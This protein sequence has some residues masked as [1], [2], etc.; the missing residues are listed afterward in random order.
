MKPR[1]DLVAPEELPIE[2]LRDYDFEECIY[3]LLD[4]MGAE[5]LAWRKGS[6]GKKGASDGGR[7][8]EAT[9]KQILPNAKVQEEYWWVDA[10]GRKGTLEKST[11]QEVVN[12]AVG[13]PNLSVFVVATNT[14]FTNPTR[15]WIKKFQEK[16]PLPRIELW[17]GED[18]KRLISKNPQVVARLFGKALTPQGKL[19][20][21]SSKFWDYAQ[22]SD[23]E[24]LEE[25]W[26]NK[27]DIEWS[28]LSILAVLA[29]EEANGSLYQ[30]PWL[31]V[32]F[33]NETTAMT[34]LNGLSNAFYLIKKMHERGTNTDPLITCF[35]KLTA[36][37]LL[38]LGTEVTNA[39]IL[40]AFTHE[41]KGKLPDN[42]IGYVLEPIIINLMNELFDVCSSDCEKVYHTGDLHKDTENYWAQFVNTKTDDLET[43]EDE[44]HL[45]LQKTNLNCPLGVPCKNDNCPLTGDE[46][47]FSSEWL[48][49]HLETI[50]GVVK[51]RVARLDIND[52]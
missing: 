36:L 32:E 29:S 5:G 18:V 8:L 38:K 6:A 43:T 39:V 2:E 20:V 23:G 13:E 4:S 28:Y 49:E 52:D 11:V 7:D 42:I 27:Y 46:D 25:V 31:G 16:H 12:N 26:S 51:G 50:E 24:I 37:A 47:E 22:Y 34:L 10:K 1:D 19:E 14:T 35:G 30:H 33:G 45:V 15:D 41:E 17:D 21:L 40:A 9:F 3:W 44:Y 48:L